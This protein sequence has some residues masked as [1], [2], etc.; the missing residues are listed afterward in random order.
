MR[1]RKNIGE[2]FRGRAKLPCLRDQ[3]MPKHHARRGALRPTQPS[4]KGAARSDLDH[5]LSPAQNMARYANPNQGLCGREAKRPPDTSGS[6]HDLTQ[7]AHLPLNVVPLSNLGHT[8]GLHQPTNRTSATRRRRVVQTLGLVTAETGCR[9][10]ITGQATHPEAVAL[11]NLMHLVGLLMPRGESNLRSSPSMPNRRWHWANSGG[12]LSAWA[13]LR[14][15]NREILGW[16]KFIGV[17][18]QPTVMQL[19]AGCQNSPIPLQSAGAVIQATGTSSPQAGISSGTCT[20]SG[21]IAKLAA[22]RAGRLIHTHRRPR[23][24]SRFFGQVHPRTPLPRQLEQ[25]SQAT[26]DRCRHHWGSGTIWA[27]NEHSTGR[28]GW[29]RPRSDLTVR[30]APVT[31]NCDK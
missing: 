31:D 15:S 20:P 5:A 10:P 13:Q 30:P 1:T 25:P 23:R 8:A 18:N 2:H 24:G 6:D 16:R 22:S 3:T 7:S 9:N 12:T 11:A 4:K 26:H 19:G 29:G 28:T 14:A 27:S 21:P 17:S